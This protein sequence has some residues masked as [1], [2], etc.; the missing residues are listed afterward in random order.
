M[1]VFFY[2]A[3]TMPIIT[4]YNYVRAGACVEYIYNIGVGEGWW[5]E[6]ML[7]W[8]YVLKMQRFRVNPAT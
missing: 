5:G 3:Y 1:S 6:E 2:D 8:G 4:L 7:K